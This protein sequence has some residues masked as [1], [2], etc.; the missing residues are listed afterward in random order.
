MNHSPSRSIIAVNSFFIEIPRGLHIA[1]RYPIR[2]SLSNEA[3]LASTSSVGWRNAAKLIVFFPRSMRRFN[4]S[5]L[6]HPRILHPLFPS[7]EDPPP[8]WI[9]DC[10]NKNSEIAATFSHAF[11][12]LLNPKSKIA[13]PKLVLNERE[14]S[15]FIHFTPNAS[16]LTPYRITLSARAS[17]FGGIVSPICFAA[18]RLMTNSNFVGCSTG[19]SAGLAPFRIL[20]T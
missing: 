5:S 16:P 14:G 8:F 6:K 17:T 15:Q 19:R 1:K 20:S 7:S 18:F 12:L 13:N 4:V 2:Q 11:A 10:R 9:L 3:R